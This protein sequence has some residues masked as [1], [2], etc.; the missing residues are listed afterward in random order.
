[1]EV[2]RNM[3]TPAGSMQDKRETIVFLAGIEWEFLKQG[4][5]YLAETYAALGFNVIYVEP[6]LH[7]RLR[8]NDFSKV[9][10][11]LKKIT[12]GTKESVKNDFLSVLSPIGLPENNVLFRFLN[13]TIFLP[14]LARKVR[15]IVKDEKLIVYVWWP[16]NSFLGLVKM[17]EP[18]RLIYSCVDN[19]SAFQG[20]PE[21]LPVVERSLVAITNSV[22]V[23]SDVL[24]E[25]W[26]A[27]HA[28]VCLRPRAVDYQLFKQSDSGPIEKLERL[29]FYGGISQRVDIELINDIGQAGYYVDLY[30][31]WRV[32][33]VPLHRNTRYRGLLQPQQLPSVIRRYDAIV[34]PYVLD[35]YTAGILPAKLY[36]CCTSGKPIFSTA[37][38]SLK[39]YNHLGI[40]TA[41]DKCSFLR[42]LENF[43]TLDD[44]QFYPVRVNEAKS[45]SWEEL[46]KNEIEWIRKC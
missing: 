44:R 14:L 18:F 1:M 7:R 21:W 27:R 32:E 31:E 46:A 6:L 2:V 42:N 12:F 30:G 8:I 45:R 38:P 20:C 5:Q 16:T 15:K 13:K 23:T 39:N 36:E 4:Q 10:N 11:R 29:I 17:L 25:T 35:E 9:I 3:S 24:L 41:V 43:N 33:K 26:K 40:Q 37:L 28:H 19:H 22:I 34:W